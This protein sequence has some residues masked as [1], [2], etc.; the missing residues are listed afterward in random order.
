MMFKFFGCQVRGG[1]ANSGLKSGVAVLE[2]F[3]MNSCGF[4]GLGNIIDFQHPE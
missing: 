2:E 3:R 4:T 1:G